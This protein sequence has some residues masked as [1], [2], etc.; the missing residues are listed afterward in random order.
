MSLKLKLRQMLIGGLL[1]PAKYRSCNNVIIL[2]NFD[3]YI[4]T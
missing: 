1:H 4:I 2:G 3:T